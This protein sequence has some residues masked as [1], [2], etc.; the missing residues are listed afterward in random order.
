[1]A[2][3]KKLIEKIL[4]NYYLNLDI[5]ELK[6]AKLQMLDHVSV[7]L[8]SIWIKNL[9]FVC[10]IQGIRTIGLR[11]Q[12]SW[13]IGQFKNSKRKISVFI[14]FLIWEFQVESVA[15]ILIILN[16]RIMKGKKSKNLNLNINIEFFFFW[17]LFFLFFEIYNHFLFFG[18]FPLNILSYLLH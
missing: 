6:Q 14:K 4:I 3:L 11:I 10:L 16:L 7:V 13:L 5:L 15:L 12:W 18:N 1:M 8:F 17:S 2:R 9:W